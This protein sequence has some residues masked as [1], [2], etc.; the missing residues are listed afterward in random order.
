MEDVFDTCRE[1]GLQPHTVLCSLGIWGRTE[2]LPGED[3]LR[4]MTL[5]GHSMVSEALIDSCV[6]QVRDGRMRV[7]RAAEKLAKPCPCGIFNVQKALKIIRK[8]VAA[9][10]PEGDGPPTAD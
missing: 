6:E 9:N 3:H 1:A 5:C 2:R 7:E 10:K 4:I 8:M